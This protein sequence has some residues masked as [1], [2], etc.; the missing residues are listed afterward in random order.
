MGS[1]VSKSLSTNINN[2][3]SVFGSFNKLLFYGYIRQQTNE[4]HIFIV[5]EIIAQIYQYFGTYHQIMYFLYTHNQLHCTDLK[6][7][8]KSKLQ[9][10]YN[11]DKSSANVREPICYQNNIQFKEDTNSYSKYNAIFRAGEY[12]YVYG[13]GERFIDYYGGRC[14]ALIWNTNEETLQNAVTVELPRNP[15]SDQR[16]FPNYTR[17]PPHGQSIIFSQKQNCLFS[18]GLTN[19]SWF[20]QPALFF[21]LDFNEYIIDGTKDKYEDYTDDLHIKWK[22]SQ[23]EH[24]MPMRRRRG[25]MT[26]IIVDN[27]YNEQ[28]I[29]VGGSGYDN[30]N[31]RS[32]FVDV[33]DFENEKWS[34]LNDLKS[35]SRVECGL[36]Y[37][38]MN[39]LLYCGGGTGGNDE[40][41]CYIPTEYRVEYCDLNKNKWFYKTDNIPHTSGAHMYHP[42]I[43]SSDDNY[44]LFI[45]SVCANVIEYIDL[46]KKNKCWTFLC[47]LDDLFE[48]RD[49]ISTDTHNHARIFM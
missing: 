30:F 44:L 16:F 47:K 33:Y 13:D 46:R 34:K 27:Y 23:M 9:I 5:N 7:M 15:F 22:W 18:I 48:I 40:I 3:L 36:Y 26:C 21:K 24:Q 4:L 6:T 11:S 17:K 31:Y 2:K 29:C 20:T 41:N 49:G 28:L 32:N 14:N 8:R 43:W 39:S 19:W 1:I 37:D 45:A 38:K 42:V 25:L 35:G 10:K 12:H